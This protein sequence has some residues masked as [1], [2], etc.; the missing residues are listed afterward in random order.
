MNEKLNVNIPPAALFENATIEALSKIAREGMQNTSFS[1]SAVIALQPGNP[2]P[3]SGAPCFYVHQLG[4]NGYCYTE[5]GRLLGAKHPFYALHSPGLETTENGNSWTVESIEALAS[6]YVEAIKT[7]EPKGPYHLGGWSFGGIV[8]FE[9]ARQLRGE[10]C[11]LVL[12]D[13]FFYNLGSEAQENTWLRA[14]ASDDAQLLADVFAGENALSLPE[15]IST[16][17]LLMVLHYAKAHNMVPHDADLSYARRVAALVRAQLSAARRY[18]PATYPGHITLF[19]PH[20]SGAGARG[21]EAIATGGVEVRLIP[22]NHAT[23]GIGE[24]AAAIARWYSEHFRV[25]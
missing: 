17:R 9:M 8:A 13:T 4:G 5:L 3:G 12:L 6:K 21:L 25:Q 7:R 18:V 22:G 23:M 2:P 19:K 24:G 1:R 11:S 14:E 10:V 16:D 15:A 20:L